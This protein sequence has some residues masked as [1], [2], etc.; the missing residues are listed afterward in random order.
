M[1]FLASIKDVNENN[2]IEMKSERWVDN[3]KDSI[4]KKFRTRQAL[5]EHPELFQSICAPPLSH[6]FLLLF[7]FNNTNDGNQCS[8]QGWEMGSSKSCSP[9][10]RSF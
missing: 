4:Y 2:A 10:R 8:W 3:F 5:Y 6:V 7:H 9:Q 1:D